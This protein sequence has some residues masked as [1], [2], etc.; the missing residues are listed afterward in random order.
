MAEWLHLDL[1]TEAAKR[2]ELIRGVEVEL[3]VSPYDIP[4]AVRGYFS[5]VKDRFV[6][7]FKYMAYEPTETKSEDRYTSLV[8][9]KNSRRLYAIELDVTALQV[10]KVELRIGVVKEVNDTLDHLLQRSSAQTRLDNYRLAKDAILIA[11]E[12]LFLP[13]VQGVRNSSAMVH[14]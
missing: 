6:V 4:E 14:M 2:H 3:S 1:D 8:L 5:E 10:D 11:Q 12:Q 9:G 13:L 7:E